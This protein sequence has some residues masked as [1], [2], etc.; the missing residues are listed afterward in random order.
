[1]KHKQ[2]CSCKK[3]S[4]LVGVLALLALG[5][6]SASSM[7][8]WGG[9]SNHD[10]STK[11][12]SI[13]Y[14][15]FYSIKVNLVGTPSPGQKITYSVVDTINNQSVSVID[16]TVP[17]ITGNSFTIYFDNNPSCD[18]DIT[19]KYYVG[20]S[21]LSYKN[22]KYKV[23]TGFY[24][25]DETNLDTTTR[26]AFGDGIFASLLLDGTIKTTISYYKQFM[27][28][29]YDTPV[30]SW[31]GGNYTVY[32]TA[33]SAYYTTGVEHLVETLTN[34]ITVTIPWNFGGGA[35]S[36]YVSPPRQGQIMDQIVW[37]SNPTD[38]DY[39]SFL[40]NILAS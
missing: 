1:M 7:T 36:G 20:I 12:K 23:R 13:Q 30:V 25:T 37:P 29:V 24:I 34:N 11:D 5:N 8:C 33:G 3:L 31:S 19:H 38:F 16:E 4:L 32:E 10:Y 28:V 21:G 26:K 15:G 39:Q 22:G 18:K 35:K 17:N 27:Q 9:W 14:T 2:N 40:R 6:A